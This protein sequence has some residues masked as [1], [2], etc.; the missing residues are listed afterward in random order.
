[1]GKLSQTE[2]QNE[3]VLFSKMRPAKHSSE[4]IVGFLF[5]DYTDLNPDV[6]WPLFAI[7]L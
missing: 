6:V 4:P 5:G 7:L 1:M 2:G 3:A